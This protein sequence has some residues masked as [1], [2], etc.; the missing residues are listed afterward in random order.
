MSYIHVLANLVLTSIPELAVEISHG[1][2][3]LA[4]TP[5]LAMYVL[6]YFL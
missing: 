2:L 3:A 1:Q 4:R 6:L 5:E